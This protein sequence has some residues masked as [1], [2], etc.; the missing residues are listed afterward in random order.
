[1]KRALEQS[2]EFGR[3]VTLS[4]DP[5]YDLIYLYEGSLF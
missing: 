5:S 1:M 2:L 3:M 4:R